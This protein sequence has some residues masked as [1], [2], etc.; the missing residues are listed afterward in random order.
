MLEQKAMITNV[1][2]DQFADIDS[3]QFSDL[4]LQ[5]LVTPWLL[6]DL[7]PDLGR[8]EIIVI[9]GVELIEH[10]SANLIKFDEKLQPAGS[11]SEP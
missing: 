7:R 8:V 4:L 5:G 3:L 9:A 10:G 6:D 11:T 1:D 2:F